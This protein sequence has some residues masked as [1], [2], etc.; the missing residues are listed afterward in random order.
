MSFE[1]NITSYCVESRVR[2][3][4]GGRTLVVFWLTC[5]TVCQLYTTR[6]ETFV[7]T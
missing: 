4:Q 7:K 2:Q 5:A 3:G 1:K 6:R